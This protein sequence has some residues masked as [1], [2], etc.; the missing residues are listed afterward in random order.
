[1]AGGSFRLRPA[2]ADVVVVGH[3]AVLVGVGSAALTAAAAN[4]N[5]FSVDIHIPVGA[6]LLGVVFF[7]YGFIQR[8]KQQ[9]DDDRTD[10]TGDAQGKHIPRP[11]GQIIEFTAQFLGVFHLLDN[12]RGKVSRDE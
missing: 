1:M 5:A 9:V 3:G 11:A 6:V 10:R 4:V 12:L 7:L 2:A 8:I